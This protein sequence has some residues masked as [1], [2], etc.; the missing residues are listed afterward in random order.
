MEQQLRDYI[1]D[2]GHLNVPAGYSSLGNCVKNQ[3]SYHKL[4][5][6]GKPEF[7][8]TQERAKELEALGFKWSAECPQHWKYKRQEEQSSFI[9]LKRLSQCC[10]WCA[11]P[12][13]IEM[14]CGP[15]RNADMG[16]SLSAKPNP[17]MLLTYF[18][19]CTINKCTWCLMLEYSVP[20][21]L[22]LI[23]HQLIYHLTTKW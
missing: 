23:L 18:Y 9:E 5:F 15:Y 10:L 6:E 17:H 11:I 3:R 19:L 13:T 12:G 1:K 14:R 22:I 21:I 2:Y 7:G 4:L 16:I 20:P 8:M